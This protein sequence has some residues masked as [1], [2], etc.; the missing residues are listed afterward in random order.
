MQCIN[1]C[2]FLRHPNLK[3]NGGE[4]CCRSCRSLNKHG[5]ACWKQPHSLLNT[6]II[7]SINVYKSPPFLNDQLKNISE[8]MKS[9]YVV[10]LNCNT[11]ML[12]TLK[13]TTLAPNVYVN[14]VAINK[15]RF[16]GS[17]TKGIVSNMQYA[18][19]KFSFKYFIIL[20]ARTVFYRDL[21][22][23]NLEEINTYIP[24]STINK[25]C[26]YTLRKIKFGRVAET[27]LLKWH[28]PSLKNTLLAKYY[29]NKRFKLYNVAHEGLCFNTNVVNTIMKFLREHN[30]IQEELFTWESTVEEFA[31]Q[32]I[33]MNEIKNKNY[34]YMY[35]G[36][37]CYEDVNMDLTD[38]YVK[39]I[40]FS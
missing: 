22:T 26:D 30:D 15:K 38:R 4:Y 39:K 27:E 37:G 7:I 24:D 12:N 17:L 29:L 19:N 16:H 13:Q 33:A 10:I 40:P 20:S 6:D 11:L 36:N 1:Y 25:K 21:S 14:P 31:L 9:T 3:N 32:T 8:H 18:L 35:I 5:K 34:G 23:S 2:G 28:W